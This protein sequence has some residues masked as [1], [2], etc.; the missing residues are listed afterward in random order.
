MQSGSYAYLFESAEATRQAD[1]GPYTFCHFDFTFMHR[2]NDDLKGS[3]ETCQHDEFVNAYK[4]A[5][6]A[7][8]DGAPRGP[9]KYSRFPPNLTEEAKARSDSRASHNISP[10]HEDPR[11]RTSPLRFSSNKLA[12]PLVF[13]W[14]LPLSFSPPAARIA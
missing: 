12:I 14:P 4:E 9:D 8:V 3:R 2:A 6:S 5:Q 13:G 1:K 10:G 11:V 7:R